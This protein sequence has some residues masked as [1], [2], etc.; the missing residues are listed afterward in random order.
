MVGGGRRPQDGDVPET[1]IESLSRVI[2]ALRATFPLATEEDIRERVTRVHGRFADA[3][4]R[5]Y[6]PVLVLRQVRA[7]LMRASADDRRPR[8]VVAG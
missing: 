6:V 1:E 7:E 5:T 2:G 3:T 8:P 4:V